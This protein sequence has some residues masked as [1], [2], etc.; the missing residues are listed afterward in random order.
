[1]HVAEGLRPAIRSSLTSLVCLLL[2]AAAG[3]G[4]GSGSGSGSG[5][6][7]QIVSGNWFMALPGNAFAGGS[8]IQTGNSISGVLHVTGSPCFDP[9]ADELIVTGKSSTDG[10]NSITFTSAPIRGQVLTVHGVY[11]AFLALHS[12]PNFLVPDLDTSVTITGGGCAG[13]QNTEAENLSVQRN[14]WG[15]NA[16][17]PPG[18][19]SGTANLTQGAPDGSGVSHIAGTFN[20]TNTSCFTTGTVSSGS[21]SGDSV[22]M[23]INTDSGQLVASGTFI[24]TFIEM[25]GVDIQLSLDAVIQGGTCNGQTPH[26][27][28]Q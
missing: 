9:N 5:P 25:L 13:Q 10:S 26:L 22:Q 16:G 2:I 6:E 15:V 28:F 12:P 7:F 3:C 21:V 4:G 18:T 23:T 1:M 11:A 17:A 27:A 19:V 24:N 8:L 20:F 14:S